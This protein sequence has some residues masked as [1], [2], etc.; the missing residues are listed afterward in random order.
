MAG[1]G[2]VLEIEAPAK[3]KLLVGY[4]RSERPEFLQVPTGETDA[5]A[6]DL[7]EQA[8]SIQNAATIQGMPPLDIHIMNIHE[9]RQVVDMHGRGLFV[10]LGVVSAKTD[11]PERDASLG[12]SKR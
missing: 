7:I 11:V 10:I 5:A 12:Q 6:A 8:A 1:G 2:S 3:L 9:G 4:F